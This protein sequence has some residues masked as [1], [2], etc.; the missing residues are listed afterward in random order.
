MN[1]NVKKILAYY[2]SLESR[3]GYKYVIWE[4]KHFG[5]YPSG[6]KTISEKKA[7]ELMRERIYKSLKFTPSSLVLDAGCGYGVV[8]CYLA[9]KYG[10]N[11][12]GID[13]NPRE[14]QRA[15]ERTEEIGLT[16]K[17]KFLEMDYSKT[18][19]PD[20]HFDFI[21]TIE[22]F[23]HSQ[24]YIKT[25]KEFYRILKS[26]GKLTIFDYSFASTNLFSKEDLRMHNIIIEKIATPTFKLIKHDEFPRTMQ[27]VGFKNA[28][29]QA[30]TK[31]IIPSIERLYK[32]ARWPYK[33]IKL[34]RLEAYFINTMVGVLWYE[35][36]TKD[37]MRYCIFTA[38]KP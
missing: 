2:N 4:A 35:L 25:L 18:N 38:E 10:P 6:K 16:N 34:F 5:Y 37:L 22:A 17:V 27:A 30:I 12:I 14:L 7:Q 32:L 26:D 15:R 24:N 23:C 1:K 19:F 11:I 33:I 29:Q 13:L 8:S 20:N 3:L 21:Y 36:F 28:K 31:N 9:K